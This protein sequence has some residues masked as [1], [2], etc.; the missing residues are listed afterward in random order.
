[1]CYTTIFCFFSM[2]YEPVDEGT[3]VIILKSVIKAKLQGSELR[4][5]LLCDFGD[6]Q[7]KNEIFRD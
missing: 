5:L 3:F 1:M 7:T 4:T 2:K 6:L